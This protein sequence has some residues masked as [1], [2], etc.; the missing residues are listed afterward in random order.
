[1]QD[2]KRKTG[3]NLAGRCSWA[4]S[5]KGYARKSSRLQA[6]VAYDTPSVQTAKA[7]PSS[8]WPPHRE[9]ALISIVFD[10]STDE[11]ADEQFK[12]L[13]QLTEAEMLQ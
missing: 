12:E 9:R 10:R 4:S 2:V 8:S 6:G 11:L 13:Y 3:N 5:G 7:A 1:V